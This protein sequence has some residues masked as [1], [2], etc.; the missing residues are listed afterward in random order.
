LSLKII[1]KLS[2]LIHL[3]I[4]LVLSWFV[5]SANGQTYPGCF[6][7]TFE[8]PR[9][10]AV[11]GEIDQV[12]IGDFNNDGK[13]DMAT[14]G[15]TG[16]FVL[17]GDG[18]GN[19]GV[20]VL[21]N[22]T[23]SLVIATGDFNADGNVDLVNGN[24]QIFLGN[25]SGSFSS[26]STFGRWNTR[27]L[28]VADVDNDGKTDVLVTHAVTY[29][30]DSHRFRIYFGDG[31]GGF[32]SEKEVQTGVYWEAFTTGPIA[33]GDFDQDGD[34]DVA[35]STYNFEGSPDGY[36]AAIYL[37]DG[38]GNFS[39]TSMWNSAEDLI[40]QD[41]NRDG[42]LDLAGAWEGSGGRNGGPAFAILGDGSGGFGG[43]NQPNTWG[44]WINGNNTTQ[45]LIDTI[46]SL[47]GG[48]SPRAGGVADFNFDGI[49]DLLTAGGGGGAYPINRGLVLLGD[50][51]GGF[52][53]STSFNMGSSAYST[54]I[55]TADFNMDGRPD[56]VISNWQSGS[57]SVFV[58][59]SPAPLVVN[60][61]FDTT[62]AYRR[63]STIPIKLSLSDRCGASVSSASKIVTAYELRLA[64]GTTS[65]P[66][67]DS[68]NANPDYNFRYVSGG[69]GGSYMFNLS[70][71]G[72]GAGT[73][74][75]YFNVGNNNAISYYVQFEIR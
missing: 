20:P 32:F 68:G 33:V 67:V 44:P 23:P 1:M 42:K 65:S 22:D 29:A 70:T 60:S 39:E 66:V 62:R 50:G 18:T 36:N 11:P 37:N 2:I 40:A 49:P 64:G 19:F 17:L 74:K 25:G 71:R 75:L 30:F 72:L 35:V 6:V 56:I 38:V 3:W 61:L 24:T 10:F 21:V 69:N 57:V 31:A 58:N 43:T 13:P 51:V 28:A 45:Q 59:S 27:E 55:N 14:A 5:A 46:A 15:S 53:P 7:P 12:A 9:N 63:G 48:Y 47:R 8:T 16:T 26:G 52:V 73:Y 41:F 54:W 4:A 34:I